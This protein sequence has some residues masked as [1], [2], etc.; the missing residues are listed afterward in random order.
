MKLMTIHLA[1]QALRVVNSW[2]RAVGCG[3]IDAPVTAAHIYRGLRGG[4]RIETP[5]LCLRV[6]EAA[7]TKLTV[8]HQH[9]NHFRRRPD[10]RVGLSSRDARPMGAYRFCGETVWRDAPGQKIRTRVP[11]GRA[12]PAL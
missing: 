4:A 2:G 9:A 3:R 12:A 7:V 10:R 5:R 1:R 11:A 8:Q 6:I